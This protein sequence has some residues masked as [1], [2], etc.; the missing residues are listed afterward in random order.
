MK[1]VLDK[2][3]KVILRNPKP[4]ETGFFTSNYIL[5]E[6]FTEITPELTWS[7][8]RRYSDFIWLK[9]SIRVHFPRLFGP[10]IPVWFK[11]I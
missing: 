6:V 11:K 2:N 10:I 4:I 9:Q 7:V 8:N 3:I 5:Y 1:K